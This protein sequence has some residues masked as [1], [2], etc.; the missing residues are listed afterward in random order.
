MGFF[1][2]VWNLFC[3][4]ER[5]NNENGFKPIIPSAIIQPID[6]AD[7]VFSRDLLVPIKRE[8]VCVFS[9]CIK[10]KPEMYPFFLQVACY[11]L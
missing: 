1:S 7:F 9:T 3:E 5:V 8:R 2:G 4:K 10:H 6:L 11:W